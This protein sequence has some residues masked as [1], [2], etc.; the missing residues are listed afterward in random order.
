MKLLTLNTH[1]LQEEGYAKKLEQFVEMV[2]REQ[3][4][5][6]ALQ[7]VNQTAA[8]PCAGPNLLCGSA[9]CPEEA[10]SVRQ[11][12]HAAQAARRLREKG[13]LCSW[14]WCSAKLGYG[15]YDEGMAILCPER[16]I[17]QVDSFYIS[18]SRDY[19]NWKT[20]KALG[21]RVRGLSGWF[22]TVH[23]GWWKDEEE[24][25]DRQWERLNEA[26]EEKKREGAVWLLGD[27]N[28]P[29][30]IRGEGYDRIRDSGWQDTYSLAAQKDDG[31]TVLGEIDGWRGTSGDAQA[32]RGMRMDHIWC[33]R[34]VPVLRSRVRFDGIGEPK[35]SDHFGVLVETGDSVP[36]F[37]NAVTGNEEE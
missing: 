4:D 23:M 5:I 13:I 26:L 21:I 1:S 11:D 19:G 17:A 32:R 27:F 37:R 8:A 35:V 24:P 9:L 25:F 33:S 7:E 2:Q 18:G 34:P 29:A 3:P 36:E 14:T 28:S 15:I 6:I 20:R 30:E 12:N 16:E 22:Y 31:I 10:V